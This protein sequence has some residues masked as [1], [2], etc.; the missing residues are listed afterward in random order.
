[1]SPVRM[2]NRD[3]AWPD[4]YLYLFIIRSL[5]EFNFVPG[6]MLKK[7]AFWSN[8]SYISFLWTSKLNKLFYMGL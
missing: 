4:L 3:F 1:M 8:M 6:E 7:T 2:C 5:G